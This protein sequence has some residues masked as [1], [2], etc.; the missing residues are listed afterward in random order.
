MSLGASLVEPK[1]RSI[2]MWRITIIHMITLTRHDHV[3]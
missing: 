2:P 1:V 3:H